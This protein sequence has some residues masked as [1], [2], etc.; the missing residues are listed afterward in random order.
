MAALQLTKLSPTDSRVDN[1]ASSIHC[2]GLTGTS[3]EIELCC[4]LQLYAV[5]VGADYCCHQHKYG[6]A[7]CKLCG[8]AAKCQW[9]DSLGVVM[10][11]S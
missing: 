4:D 5:V 9:P 10:A 6:K 11:W 1:Q 3:S 8:S 2:K 7:D